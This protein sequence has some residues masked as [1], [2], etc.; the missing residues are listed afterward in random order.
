MTLFSGQ[1]LSKVVSALRKTDE[2]W[3]IV[4]EGPTTV[5]VQLPRMSEDLRSTFVSKAKAATEECKMQIRR[6][7]QESRTKLHS[8]LERPP[9][10]EDSVK[11][12]KEEE[13]QKLTDEAIKQASNLLNGKLKQ[14]ATPAD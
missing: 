12:E 8:L 3:A 11:R 14:F 10:L 5:R 2:S 1:H 9:R 13:L 7:R 6:V 4:E